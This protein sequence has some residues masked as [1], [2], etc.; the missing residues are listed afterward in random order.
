MAGICSKPTKDGL[1]QAYYIDCLG[2]RQYL[3]EATLKE[4]LK[5]AHVVAKECVEIRR[6]INLMGARARRNSQVVRLMGVKKEF[7]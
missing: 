2:R 6:L 3:I 4:A 7:T 5:T 1:Y